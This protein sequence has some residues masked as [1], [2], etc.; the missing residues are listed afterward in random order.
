[1][2]E[3]GAHRRPVHE[4]HTFLEGRNADGGFE[5]RQGSRLLALRGRRFAAAG[6]VEA[7]GRFGWSVL[8]A[9]DLRAAPGPVVADAAVEFFWNELAGGCVGRGDWTA[10]C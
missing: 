5:V 3:K 7:A 6:A 2:Y 8:A 10:F 1:M 9:A 4:T